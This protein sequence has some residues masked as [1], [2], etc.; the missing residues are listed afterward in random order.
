MKKKAKRHRKL[1]A[2]KKAAAPKNKHWQPPIDVDATTDEGSDEEEMED[3]LM[4]VDNQPGPSKTKEIVQNSEPVSTAG[5]PEKEE[6]EKRKREKR[7]KRVQRKKDKALKKAQ[8]T[9]IEPANPLEVHTPGSMDL[10]IPEEQA[11]AS[12]NPIEEEDRLEDDLQDEKKVD[13]LASPRSVSAE[14][15]PHLIPFPLP[16]PAATPSQALLAKQGLPAG[17]TDAEFIDQGLRIAVS[18]LRHLQL[19]QETALGVRMQSRLKESGVEEFFAGM[20]LFMLFLSEMCA[21]ESGWLRS[22][23]DRYSSSCH[24]TSAAIRIPYPLTLFPLARLPHLCPDRLRKDFGL[25][26]TAHRGPGN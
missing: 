6:R 1:A 10:K 17:L 18:E 21:G 26:D 2:A 13:P 16:T 9:A 3:G 12:Q 8:S 25:R 19:G 20:C 15:P 4:D 5:Y 22:A 24:S 23:A 11:E 14:S 7:E